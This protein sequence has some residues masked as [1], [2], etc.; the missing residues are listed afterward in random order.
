MGVRYIPLEGELDAK[1]RG[2]AVLGT[3]ADAPYDDEKSFREYSFRKSQHYHI[4]KTLLIPGTEIGF[5]LIA[6][7]DFSF[8]PL[9]AATEASPARVPEGIGTFAADILIRKSDI[10]LYA[11][12]VR[13]LETASP[14]SEHE[15][16]RIR[17]AVLRE[18][19]KLVMKELLE[20]PR[21]GRHI[22]ECGEA[23]DGMITC[24]LDNREAIHDLLSIMNFDYYTYTHSVN[25]SVLS[26]GLGIA[27]S[28]PREDLEK[29]GLGAMLHDIGK[30]AIPLDLL[31]KQGRLTDVEFGVLRTHVLQGER[32]LR[33][34]REVP[35]ESLTAVSQ[36]HEKLSGRGY[37]RRLPGK[38]ITLFGRIAGIADCYDALTTKR[39]YKS[40][41]PP[42]EALSII[43]RETEDYDRDLLKAFISMLGSTEQQGARESPFQV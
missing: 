42:F 3:R 21:S 22:R 16:A 9:L 41:F 7:S 36:H 8:E 19:S 4:D 27:T 30:S 24:I 38:A 40:A 17:T 28:L 34:G 32:I 5:S 6:H 15:N 13:S 37:P 20:H 29:L 11:A 2:G 39:P 23:V 25:V 35:E 43:V 18:N 1:D 26:I 33:E 31:N 10:P 12:Y 14:A